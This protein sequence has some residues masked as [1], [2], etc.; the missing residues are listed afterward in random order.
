MEFSTAYGPK[1]KVTSDPVGESLA[2]QGE[3][4]NC[5][6]NFIIAK[7]HKTGIITHGKQYNGEYGNFAK[8]DFHEAMNIVAEAEQMFQSIPSKI[9]AEFNNDPGQ[10]IDFA[11]NPDNQEK[12]VEYGLG[13]PH[14]PVLDPDAPVVTPAPEPGQPTPTP[15]PT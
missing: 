9:R 10:F 7:Y 14:V 3:K 8:I 5:D 6:I 1:K 15:T 12:M 2:K 13:L 11:I 4:K